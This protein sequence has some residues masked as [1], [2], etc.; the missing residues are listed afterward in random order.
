MRLTRS[1]QRS[2]GHSAVATRPDLRTEPWS[3]EAPAIVPNRAVTHPQ[4][5]IGLY[6]RA[7]SFR[8]D[9]LSVE[10]ALDGLCLSESVRHFF[11]APFVASS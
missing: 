10:A 4:P 5:W 9:A 8:L 6:H 7:W 2:S 11:P 3:A 1:R